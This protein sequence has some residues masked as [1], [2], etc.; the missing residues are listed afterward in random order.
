M[1]LSFEPPMG[2]FTG[3]FSM[4][5]DADSLAQ[6]RAY[7]NQEVCI[8]FTRDLFERFIRQVGYAAAFQRVEYFTPDHVDEF[9]R[10]R[11]AKMLDDAVE[12]VIFKDLEP[13]FQLDIGPSA[14]LFMKHRG[15]SSEREWRLIWHCPVGGWPGGNYFLR[16]GSRYPIPTLRIPIN[17]QNDISGIIFGPGAD[18]DVIDHLRRLLRDTMMMHHWNVSSSSIPYRA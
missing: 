10:Q 11:L 14:A 9:I 3:V 15:F 1:G 12:S 6:W 7:G 5:T 2:Y 8:E 4:S 16:P 13:F 18:G 17:I